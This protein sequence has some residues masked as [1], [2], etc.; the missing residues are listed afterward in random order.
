[1]TTKTLKRLVFL[2]LAKIEGD[3]VFLTERGKLVLHH[4][5]LR[6]AKR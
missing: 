5:R 2:G 1:M 3:R 4:L 6:Q